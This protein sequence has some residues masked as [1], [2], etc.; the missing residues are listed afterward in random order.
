MN[1]DSLDH[2]FAQVSRLHHNRLH[3]LLGEFGV[4]QGQPPIL[5]MLWDKDGRSQKEIVERLKVKP[6]TVTVMLKR[7]EKA[8]WLERRTDSIDL[9]VSR[10]YLTEKGRNIQSQVERAIQ[11]L[12]EEF[13]TGFTQEE[14]IL[15]RRFLLH[16]KEN[17]LQVCRPESK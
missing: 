8:G 5:F 10:V 13:L 12:E 6:A 7:M 4:Y 2:L 15:L 9:R 17:L 16:M 3:M 11:Q 14:R 1:R